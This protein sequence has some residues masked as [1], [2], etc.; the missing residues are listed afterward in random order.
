MTEE[1]RP[2]NSGNPGELV[3]MTLRCA[4]MLREIAAQL[5][6]LNKNLCQHGIVQVEVLRPI[7]FEA[8]GTMKDELHG[9]SNHE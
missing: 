6:E 7:E 5:A 1:F 9:N 8:A 2:Y 4:E 3:K